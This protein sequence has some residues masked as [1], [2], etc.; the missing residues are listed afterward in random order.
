MAA[1]ISNFFC[2]YSL[3]III[4]MK[5]PLLYQLIDIPD[6]LIQAPCFHEFGIGLTK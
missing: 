5:M 3:K 2:E 6:E 1:L 4:E